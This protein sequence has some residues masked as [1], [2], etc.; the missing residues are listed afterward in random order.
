M[1]PQGLA[2]N[3]NTAFQDHLR[4]MEGQG[5]AFNSRRLV[6]IP[7][8]KIIQQASKRFGREGSRPGD[9]CLFCAQTVEDRLDIV[10]SHCTTSVE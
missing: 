5:V 1:F 10:H 4:L 9:F 3:C 8:Q 7:N 6:G 2:R